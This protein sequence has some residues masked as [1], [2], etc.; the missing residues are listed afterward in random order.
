MLNVC[1]F[2]VAA[3]KA[4]GPC[5]PKS[6]AELQVLVVKTD[7]ASAKL[8]ASVIFPSSRCGEVAPPSLHKG[9]DRT[10]QE[11]QLGFS[12]SHLG[13]SSSKSLH[14]AQ[15]HKP[16]DTQANSDP[17]INT[18]Q[19]PLTTPQ[20]PCNKE[21]HLIQRYSTTKVKD[22]QEDYLTTQTD[23]PNVRR[24]QGTALQDK[25][26]LSNLN[27]PRDRLH[28]PASNAGWGIPKGLG[29]RGGGESSLN[30]GTS[31]WGT[32]PASTSNAGWGQNATAQNA[33]QGASQWG[34]APRPGPPAGP[35]PQPTKGS[36]SPQQ[37]TQQ[38]QPS[39]QLNQQQP[40]TASSS[41]Q[42]NGGQQQQQNQP[43][44]QQPSQAGGASGNGQGAPAPNGSP[45]WAQAAGGAGGAGGPGKG[46]G[47]PGQPPGP[48]GTPTT[49][50]AKQLEQ[51]NSMREALLSQDG[52][53]GVSTLLNTL[54]FFNLARVTNLCLV[55]LETTGYYLGIK[56]IGDF[57]S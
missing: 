49:A 19:V 31:G 39:Q 26:S 3:A 51:I 20:S 30:N 28:G 56:T 32:P 29:L 44:S 5:D 1:M 15:S 7:L 27:I 10:S 45:S 34:S 18:S 37:S 46:P 11:A 57:F 41:Q 47:G 36:Q 33:T 2:A 54:A 52:W 13:S 53:G 42:G 9:S 23:G 40:T 14:C 25:F 43:P 35:N 6:E 17:K 12:A 8:S 48:N 21:N 38:Q 22:E 55:E 50:T 4:A 16:L 24:D